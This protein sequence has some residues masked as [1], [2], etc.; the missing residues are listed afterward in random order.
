MLAGPI[1]SALLKHNVAFGDYGAG[2]YEVVVL[3]VGSTMILSAVIVA[4]RDLQSAKP[5]ALLRGWS[6]WRERERE[7]PSHRCMRYM[8]YCMHRSWRR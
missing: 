2:K 4:F 6:L 1:G 8:Q 5:M 3:F 7:R